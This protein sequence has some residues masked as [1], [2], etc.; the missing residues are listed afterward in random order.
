MFPSVIKRD[1]VS[2]I[3]PTA[4]GGGLSFE[5]VPQ[6]TSLMDGGV[7]QHNPDEN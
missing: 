6:F 5:S 3:P 7:E 1:L 2:G 4:N